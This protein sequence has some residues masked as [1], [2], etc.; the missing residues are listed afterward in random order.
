MYFS[1]W[2][3]KT[4]YLRASGYKATQKHRADAFH[5]H[6]EIYDG[7]YARRIPLS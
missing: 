5:L 6:K 7:I 3:A 2:T 1:S 4:C